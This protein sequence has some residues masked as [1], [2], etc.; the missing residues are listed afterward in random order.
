[1]TGKNTGAGAPVTN[2][3]AATQSTRANGGRANATTAAEGAARRGSRATSV[4]DIYRSP[5]NLNRLQGLMAYYGGLTADQLRVEA[6]KLNDLPLNERMPASFLLF[7]R[8]AE[9]D[10][11]GAMAHSNSMGVGGMF[12]RPTI[13]QSWASLDPANAAKYYMENPGQFT[14][15]GGRGMGGGQDAA[16]IIATEWAR[17]DPQGAL[18]W[19]GSLTQGKSEALAAVLGEVAKSDPRAATEMVSQLNPADRADA[20]VSIAGRYGA[21]DFDAAQSWIRTLPQA[22]QAAAMA[23]A[24]RGLSS[25]SPDLALAQV[26]SMAEGEAKNQLIPT[27][28]GDLARNDPQAAARFVASQADEGVQRDSVRE[29]MPVWTSQN[30]TAALAFVQSQAPGPVYD[31]AMASYVTSNV[32]GNP[33]ELITLAESID[34]D[35]ERAWSMGMTAQRWMQTDPDAARAYIQ[36]SD[37]IPDGMRDRILDG[38]GGGWGGGGRGR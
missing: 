32:N 11:H 14:M 23:A 13:L 36:Q 27:L 15:M 28:V 31:R 12:V 5:G 30:P 37:A 10:P 4:E 25:K 7:A 35:R 17:Q 1:M 8:W 18:A 16:S 19:A 33:A 20:Y 22:E 29:L 9:L 26:A 21:Q 34:S 24:I 2:D 3:E 38:R 6:E